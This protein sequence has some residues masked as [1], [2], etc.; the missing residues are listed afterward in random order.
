MKLQ[1]G[2]DLI[3]ISRLQD[4]IQR[5]GEQF[6]TRVFTPKELAEVGDQTARLAGRWAAKE[7]VSKAF[8]TGIGAMRWQ[9]IEILRGPNREPTLHLYGT[10]QALAE[11]QNLATW[12]ISLSYTKTHAIAIAVAISDQ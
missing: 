1:A 2:V 3:E 12:S 8:R 9:E 7:A 10:A 4:A 11:Q 6:L 5:H